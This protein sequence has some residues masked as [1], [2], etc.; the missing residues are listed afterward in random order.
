MA[1]QKYQKEIE[2]ILE[3]AGEKPPEDPS[4]P[5]EET[6][7]RR[8]PR[9]S[10]DAGARSFRIKYQFVLAAGIALVLLG[11]IAGWLYFFFAGVVLLVLGYVMYYRAPRVANGPTKAPRMWR[12]R[13]I[14]PEDPPGR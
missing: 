3:K 13:S 5:P 11:A 10:G 7:R 12:G 8:R 9:P 6:P 2:E 1:Q 4:R 14:D